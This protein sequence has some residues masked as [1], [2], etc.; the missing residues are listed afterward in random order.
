MQSVPLFFDREQIIIQRLAAREHLQ[1]ALREL[2]ADARAERLRRFIRDV[3][4]V[5]Q[6][7]Q[8]IVLGHHGLHQVNGHVVDILAHAGNLTLV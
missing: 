7:N 6:R 8:L 1:L 3:R 4:A 5:E 2:L